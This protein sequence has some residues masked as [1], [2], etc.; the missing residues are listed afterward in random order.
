[1]GG[2]PP[3]SANLPLAGETNLASVRPADA[4][5][6]N[7]LGEEDLFGSEEDENTGVASQPDRGLERTP[8]P[9][10]T[11]R[12][13]ATPIPDEK[14]LFGEDSD[15]GAKPAEREGGQKPDDAQSEMS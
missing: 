14:D 5:S 1:M 10:L 8:Q 9:D 4:V 7:E 12:P 3:A 13:D 2:T 6:D 15:A 11:P